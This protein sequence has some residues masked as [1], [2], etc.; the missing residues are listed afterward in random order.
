MSEPTGRFHVVTLGCKLNQFDSAQSEAIL[1]TRAMEPTDDPR[2]ADVIVVNTCTVTGRADAEGRR[3]L[4]RMR[5]LNPR[6]RIVATGC[7]AERAPDELRRVTPADAVV[8]HRDRARLP[9]ALLGVDECVTAPLAPSLADRSRGWLRVQEG[10][11]L[12]CSYCVIP[13]V[14]GPGRSVPA[15]E[16]VAQLRTFAERG[17]REV[18]L[19]GVNV[20]AWGGDLTPRRRLADLL[21][22]IVRADVG[23]RIRLNSLEPRTV[24]DEI[25]ALMREHPRVLV[26]HLQIPL[27]SGTDSV[28]ARM[29]RNYRTAFY[30]E[31]ILAAAAAVPDI[32]LGADVITGFPGETDAEHDATVRFLESLPLAYLHVFSYSRR[33]GTR[34]AELPG[35]VAPHEIKRRTTRLRALGARKGR[36]FRERLLGRTL[37]GLALHAHGPCGA[38]RVL[39]GNYVEVLVPGAP[40]GEVVAVRLE[41][42]EDDL[43]VRGALA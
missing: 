40:C 12:R 16:V 38:T 26:P 2:L 21:E 7:Y 41:R 28:L 17:V 14:R 37:D 39:T 19:T 1:R 11:D 8:G 42:L 33:P 13:Q 30:R 35:Q 3:L 6:A 25:L 24:T 34:A 32:C 20:G 10:C 43:V 4:R 15:D 29:S 27:Q 9:Q 18:G 23:L 22:A 5:R 31:R 36:A